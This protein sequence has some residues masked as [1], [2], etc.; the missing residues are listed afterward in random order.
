MA[1]DRE[2]Y[3]RQLEDER[4]ALLARVRELERKLAEVPT[5]QMSTREFYERNP[6]VT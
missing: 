5:G 3:I 4:D 1:T 2:Q 6:Q